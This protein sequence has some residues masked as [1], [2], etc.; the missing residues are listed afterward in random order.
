[1]TRHSRRHRERCNSYSDDECCDTSGNYD[2]SGNT[3]PWGPYHDGRDGHD[4]L[5]GLDGRDGRDGRPGR[6]GPRGPKG[7]HGDTG[8]Q[9]ATGDLGHTGPMGET[10]AQGWMGPTGETGAQGWMGPTGSQGSTGPIGHTGAQGLKGDTGAQ[11]LKG[12]TGAQGLKGDTGPV[13]SQTFV[14]AD[15]STDQTLAQED[16]VIFD[17]PSIQYGS[18]VHPAN[19]PDFFIWRSGYYHISFVLCHQEPCQFSIFMNGALLPGTT[20]GSPTGTSQNTLTAIVYISP[21]D[22]L[23]TPTVLSPT[24]FAA[25]LNVVNHTSFV[26]FVTLNG[27]GGSGSASPQM[28]ASMVIFLLA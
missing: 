3:G 8:S 17:F 27:L 16:S 24:G 28:V 7:C 22:V 19:S 23:G 18:A 2:M 26:P 21:S 5:D 14:H 13:F 25:K 10:G 20:V 11:G 15:R 12:D 6:D 9:G 1:M 4:G